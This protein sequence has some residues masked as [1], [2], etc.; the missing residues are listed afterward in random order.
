MSA[1]VNSDP[2]YAIALVGAPIATRC[3]FVL[4]VSHSEHVVL[5]DIGRFSFEGSADSCVEWGTIRQGGGG[6]EC[7]AVLQAEPAIS[8]FAF[9]LTKDE[10]SLP[11]IPSSRAPARERPAPVRLPPPKSPLL[12]YREI[13]AFCSCRFPNESDSDFRI[14]LESCPTRIPCPPK[15]SQSVV[16]G[17]REEG[18]DRE[19][20]KVGTTHGGDTSRCRAA[21]TACKLRS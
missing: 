17:R 6:I 19:A 20:S 14:G 1:T 4:Q 9:T 21:T 13:L 8:P 5:H 7:P 3:H 2:M 15:F 12:V 11:P 10:S 16:L 18:R